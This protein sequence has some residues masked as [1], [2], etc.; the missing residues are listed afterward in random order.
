MNGLMQRVWTQRACESDPE[1]RNSSNR[2]S[3]KHV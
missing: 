1:D 3:Y 2:S